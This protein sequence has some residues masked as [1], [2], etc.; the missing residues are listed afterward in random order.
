MVNPE[1]QSSG[2]KCP[3]DCQ[4]RPLEHRQS[5]VECRTSGT[6]L[7]CGSSAVGPSVSSSGRSAEVA[8]MLREPTRGL[9]RRSRPAEHNGSSGEGLDHRAVRRAC[10]RQDLVDQRSPS[11][12]L[13]VQPRRFRPSGFFYPAAEGLASEGPGLCGWIQLV[14]RGPQGPAGVKVAGPR[15]A[16]TPSSSKRATDAIRYFTARVKGN[17][18]ATAPGKQKLYLAALDTLP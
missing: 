14:L 3:M 17:R 6:P 10:W 13:E 12:I 9:R 11:D 15:C 8:H 1:C 16:L 5:L 2:V 7:S 4:R 18:D